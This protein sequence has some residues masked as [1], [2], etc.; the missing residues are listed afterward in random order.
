[1]RPLFWTKIPPVKLAGTVWLK[2]D[3]EGI[4]IK[5]TELVELFKKPP[6]KKKQPKKE[7]SG[8]TKE[9]KKKSVLDG[10]RQQNAGIAMTTMKEAPSVY[11]D[12]VVRCSTKLT[13]TVILTLLKLVPNTTELK[14][15]QSE[16]T[17]TCVSPPKKEKN[18]L[19][20][21]VHCPFSLHTSLLPLSTISWN[22]L[23]T[24]FFL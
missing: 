15:L 16:W 5:E 19:F 18:C 4:D 17:G 21:C 9:A 7:T 14:Q 24:Y 23:S 13:S 3:D 10:Q 2:F 11:E 8:E 12:W 6:K 1:M 20:V 22:R